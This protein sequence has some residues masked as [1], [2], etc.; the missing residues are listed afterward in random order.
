MHAEWRP[1]PEFPKYSVNSEGY[2]R[3]EESGNRM[4]MS[5]NQSGIVYVRLTKNCIQYARGVA[6]LVAGV[7]IKDKPNKNFDC[8]VNLDGDRFNN[9]AA[10]LVWRPRWFATKY[11]QQLD[12]AHFE[13]PYPIEELN[14]LEQFKNPWDASKKYGLLQADV[15]LSICNGTMVWPT[16]QTFRRTD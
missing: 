9:R 15:L 10:N 3:N 5:V 13:D 2:I 14:T 1:I 4:A 16:K 7:Y 8:A 6:L 12:E 11:F